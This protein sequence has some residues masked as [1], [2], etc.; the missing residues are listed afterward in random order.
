MKHVHLVTGGTGFVG[1]CI[2]LELLR[3]TDVDVFCVVRPGKESVDV[4]LRNALETAARAYAL[5]ETIIDEIKERC[6]A[7]P[8]DVEKDM[9][10][11]STSLETPIDQFWHSAASLRYENRYAE[12]ITRTN[13]EGT[14]HALQLAHHL[15]V[16]R[17]N[18]VSTAYVAGR[19]SGTI[20]EERMDNQETNNLYEMSKVHAEALVAA[21]TDLH[22]RIFRPSIVI[23]HSKTYA[24]TNFTGL[25]GFMR[26]LLQFKGMMSRVQ[27]GYLL[28]EALRMRVDAAGLLNFVPVD[29]VAQQAV[30]IGMSSS[31][32]SIFHL[33][34]A[35][36]PTIEQFLYLLFEEIG[37]KEPLLVTNKDDFSWIDSKFDQGLDFYGS[38]MLGFK[39]FDR[40]NTDA[41]LGNTQEGACLLDPPELLSY[42]RWY[43]ER[44]AAQRSQLVA[45]R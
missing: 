17:F 39:V 38:Y 21:A 35:T 14:R 22:P 4:R 25:Y 29:M 15:G 33:T 9:C 6:Y 31:P 37:I 26:K 23:G 30:R 8:G 40:T 10:G 28:R 36:P 34:N 12:E 3:Q 13:V 16:H 20:L 19:R 2:I 18:Y 32:A 27:E 43:L 42:Y 45:S 1:A 5:D 24:A 11:I 7:V 41:A 44:L